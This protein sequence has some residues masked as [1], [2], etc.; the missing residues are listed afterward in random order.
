M[1]AKNSKVV[2]FS[3]LPTQQQRYIYFPIENDST[4]IK[5]TIMCYQ[6]LNSP[7]FDA[8]ID[9]HANAKQ[10]NMPSPLNYLRSCKPSMASLFY[11]IDL[12][13][14]TSTVM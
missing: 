14:F 5:I 2:R 10:S 4:E 7:S 9:K 13:Y 11:Q 8:T 12:H 1:I 3:K 6:S